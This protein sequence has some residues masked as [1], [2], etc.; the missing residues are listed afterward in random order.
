M[1]LHE[2]KPNIRNKGKKRIAR[3]GKRGTTSGRGQKGQSSRAGAKIKPA[4]HEMLISI[5]KM[6]GSKNARKSPAAQVISL[7]QLSKLNEATITKELLF[8][9]KLIRTLKAPVKVL[10][11]GEISKKQEYSGLLF[12]KG[13]RA[14][15]EKAG[16]EI[17]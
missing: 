8:Q 6:R 17:H 5:P 11:A 1:Q 4:Q 13:A 15:I 2:I 12:S 14:K 3:G 10:D 9:K 16:G 7:S